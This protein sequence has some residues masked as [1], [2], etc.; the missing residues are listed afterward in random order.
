MRGGTV[1]DMGNYCGPKLR[2]SRRLGV[3]IANTPKH[4]KAAEMERPGMHGQ[5][6]RRVSLYALQLHEKQK[7]T[8][9][10]NIRT[11]QLRRYLDKAAKTTGS[12]VEALQKILETRLDNVV[13]RAGW[14]RTIWQARQMVVH[15][16]ILVNDKK[17]DRPS[18]NL[19]AGDVV[20]VKEDSRKFVEAAAATAEQDSKPDWIETEKGR[21]A[22]KVLR[23]PQPD[24]VRLPFIIDYSLIIEFYSR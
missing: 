5:K 1:S 18:N 15:G 14:A 8:S 13:R 7:L 4:R 3:P 12:T 24:E 19:K 21:L 10:Y 17:V 6:R 22:C 11:R 2:L 16:H 20:T 23:V 9:Y